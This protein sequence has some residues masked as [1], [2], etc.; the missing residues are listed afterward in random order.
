MEKQPAAR[1]EEDGNG[2]RCRYR[3]RDG[4]RCLIGAAIA[5]EDYLPS[6]ELKRASTALEK[7]EYPV[8]DENQQP[9][10]IPYRMSINRLQACHDKIYEGDYHTQVKANLEEFAALEGLTIPPMVT[11]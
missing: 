10:D 11:A 6:I 1:E 8:P 4:R 2:G 7:L 9:T 5:D 3:T